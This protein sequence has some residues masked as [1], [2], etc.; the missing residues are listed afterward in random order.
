MPT[1]QCG[2]LEVI[3]QFDVNNIDVNCSLNQAT[4]IAQEGN[5]TLTL[6]VNNNQ[7]RKA[8]F[9]YT[10]RVGGSSVASETR[11]LNRNGGETITINIGGLSPGNYN[12][13]VQWDA[14]AASSP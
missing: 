3:P 6:T 2:T 10:A 8:N 7:G 12:V 9:Q 14:S 5:T 4:I 11:T 13:E 1:I